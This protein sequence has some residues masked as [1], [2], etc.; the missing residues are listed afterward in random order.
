MGLPVIAVATI[1]DSG[2]SFTKEHLRTAPFP[3][4]PN[5][6]ASAWARL[7]SSNPAGNVVFRNVY[8]LGTRHGV[9][10]SA[11]RQLLNKLSI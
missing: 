11:H 7:A 10:A 5:Y 1:H 3:V 6:E 9:F 4:H 2:V 8:G